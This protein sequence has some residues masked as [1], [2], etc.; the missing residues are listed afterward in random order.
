MNLPCK[1]CIKMA[2]ESDVQGN[3]EGDVSDLIQM[4][5]SA[6]KQDERTRILIVTVATLMEDK[7]HLMTANLN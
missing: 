1:F 6:A 4:L 7:S 2:S 5:L 3:I